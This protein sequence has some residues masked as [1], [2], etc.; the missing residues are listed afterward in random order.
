[1]FWCSCAI[2]KAGWET[3]TTIITRC[4]SSNYWGLIDVNLLFR[5]CYMWNWHPFWSL[6]IHWL[7]IQYRSRVHSVM[8]I[9]DN[10]KKELKL[11]LLMWDLMLY[12]KWMQTYECNRHLSILNSMRWCLNIILYYGKKGRNLSVC[13]STFYQHT[14]AIGTLYC[15]FPNVSYH[16]K[17]TNYALYAKH[18][19]HNNT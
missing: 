9:E 13:T 19:I 12:C 18:N 2:K 4:V 1:M 5:S 11:C 14:T 10:Y 7:W 6:S 17:R 15:S 8:T 3:L 16:N